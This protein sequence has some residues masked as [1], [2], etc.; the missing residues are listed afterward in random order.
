MIEQAFISGQLGRAIYSEGGQQFVIAADHVEEPRPC[1]GTDLA[2]F[3]RSGAE[4]F[5]PISPISRLEELANELEHNT[6]AYKALTLAISIF[7]PELSDIRGL[8]IEAAEELLAD[9]FVSAFVRR[10]LRARPLPLGADIEGALTAT[11]EAGAIA[12]YDLLNAVRAS[13]FSIGIAL[14]AWSEGAPVFFSSEDEMIEAE[15]LLVESGAFDEIITGMVSRNIGAV[16]SAVLRYSLIP[17]ISSQIP[18]V[19]HLLTA[20]RNKAR[21]RLNL[22]GGERKETEKPEHK[23][24]SDSIRDLL[25][26]FDD[27]EKR[28]RKRFSGSEAKARVDAQIDP[29]KGLIAKHDINLA[30]KWVRDLVEFQVGHGE[31]RHLGMTLCSL[32]ACALDAGETDFATALIEHAEALG[33][34]DPVIFGSKAWALKA[35]GDLL[36]ALVEFDSAIRRF[37]DDPWLRNGRAEVLKA[38]GHFDE[39]LKQYD[40]TAQRFP[41]DAVARNGRA[42]VLKAMGRFDEALGQYDETAQRFPDDAVVRNGRAEVLKAMGRF[43]EALTQYDET[44]QRFPDNAVVRNGRAEVLKAMGRFDEALMQYDETVR[45]FPDDVVVRTG[46]AEVLK[47]MG[48]FDEA[49]EQYDETV[50][51]FPDNAVARTGRAEVL[52]AMG[53]FDEAL[54]QYD[55]TI[56]RFPDN[57]VA[58]TGRAEVLKAMGRFDEA[59]GQY[60]ESRQLFPYDRRML[61]AEASVLLAMNRIMEAR[62]LLLPET[63]PVSPDDWVKFHLLAMMYLK[64]GN[65]DAAITRLSNGAERGPWQSRSFFVGSLAVARIR[66][67]EFERA[68]PLLEAGMGLL[69]VVQKQRRLVLIGHSHAAIGEKQTAV[70]SLKSIGDMVEPN[71]GGLRSLLV[72]RYELG[73]H[74][75]PKTHAE[76]FPFLDVQIAQKEFLLAIA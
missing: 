28:I 1:S 8:L 70:A 3:F 32:A 21:E 29:I 43:D 7:D 10:R 64:S 48:R 51:R 67:E 4:Y 11:K 69:D 71:I 24:E 52:K 40:E 66:K 36:G 15:K 35:A 62:D 42:E 12:T 34:E 58:R 65:L 31:K 55:E 60:R 50:Q 23:R 39:A 38:M 46:R 14:S 59:L 73:G 53:R 5:A 19:R 2:M 74:S 45:R 63:N 6:Q 68:L 13:Q 22:T 57:A 18:R 49:L 30:T 33:I 16:D 27:N 72:D 54:G 44:V 26:R 47:A 76:R 56:Q 41:D 37:P 75:Y 9:A 17:S 61:R 25:S 20:V